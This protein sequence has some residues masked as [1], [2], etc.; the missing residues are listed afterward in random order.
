MR[1]CNK[2]AYEN[3]KEAMTI[4][5]RKTKRLIFWATIFVAALIIPLHFAGEAQAE[6]T[7]DN[8]STGTFSGDISLSHTTGTGTNRLMLVGISVSDYGDPVVSSASYGSQ[9]LSLVGSHLVD[10]GGYMEGV[11]IYAL[12]NPASGTNNVVIDYSSSPSYDSVV[13]VMT[14][15]GVDQGNPLGAASCSISTTTAPTSTQKSL[16]LLLQAS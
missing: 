8:T 10:T 11:L 13:G 5:F 7:I 3:H 12:V 14:F 9:T 15:T 6:I 2:T 4:K 1:P 16:C